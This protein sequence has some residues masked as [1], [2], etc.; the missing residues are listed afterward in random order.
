LLARAEFGIKSGFSESHAGHFRLFS[1]AHRRA[2]GVH[3]RF[4]LLR[5]LTGF[6]LKRPPDGANSDAVLLS[7][8]RDCRAPAVTVGNNPLLAVVE[9]FRTPKLLALTLGALDA[10][11]GAA[12]DQ[13]ALELSNA[14]HNGQDKHSNVAR[15]VAPALSKRYEAAGEALQFMQD[16]VQV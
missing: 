3:H 2:H 1:M 4:P 9:P 16:V 11:L 6:G 5:R 13:L 8:L 14:A 10:L 12:P 15:G 7:K